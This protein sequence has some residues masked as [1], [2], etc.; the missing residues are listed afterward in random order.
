[1]PPLITPIKIS[2][3]QIKNTVDSI[4]VIFSKI[5][6]IIG[7]NE[8]R[9]SL[10]K[11]NERREKMIKK[12]FAKKAWIVTGL[13]F[14][15]ALSYSNA[16]A[17]GGGRSHEGS[18]ERHEKSHYKDGRFDMSDWFGF[19]IAIATPHIGSI[20]MSLP[21]GYRTIMAGDARYYYYDNVYYKPRSSG[22][23]IAPEP[24]ATSGVVY[25]PYTNGQPKRLTGDTVTINVPNANGSYTPVTL[26]KNNNGYIGPQG[27]YY[28]G[29]P[30]V[31]Q[32]KALYGK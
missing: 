10:Y 31:D 21:L 19:R 1:V 5:C 23:I 14:A 29:H 4:C 2:I 13:C 6:V 26:V 3:I 30:T 27:E 28:P 20:V 15:F 8:F 11:K 12:T 16:F 7:W 22:Y 17:W 24:K 32:L 25:I 18:M 9:D